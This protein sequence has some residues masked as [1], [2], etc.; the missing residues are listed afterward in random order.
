MQHFPIFLRLSGERVVVSGAGR[1]AVAKLR[2]LL[3][4]EAQLAVF[5]ADPDAEILSWQRAGRLGH[6]A[7]PVESADLEGAAL[8]YCANRDGAADD[9]AAALDR[10]HGIRV[11]IA[12]NLADSDFITPAIVDRDPVTVAIGTEGTAPVLARALKAALEAQLPTSLGPLARIAQAF[13]SRCESIAPGRARRALWSEYFFRRGPRGYAREGENGAR[14]ALRLLL[15][16]A[17]AATRPSGFV[18]FVGAG[19]GDPAL[20]TLKARDRLHDADIV[21]H[22]RLVSAQVLEL[23]RREAERVCAG[24]KGF[25]PSWSQ[26]SINALLARRAREGNHVVRLKSGDPTVFGRLD[27]EIEALDGAGI[28]WEIVPGITAAS[29]AA[30]DMGISLTRRGRN[31]ALRFL[32]GR[33]ADG[34]AEHD[35]AA[36]ARPGSVAAIYMGKRA[37]TFL[38][39]RLLMHGAAPSTPVTIVENASATDERIVATSLLRL[40]ETLEEERFDGAVVLML[41]LLPREAVRE[42]RAGREVRERAL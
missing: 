1:A 5:G 12:D 36:L 18:S 7:R 8:L 38:R 24:K 34:F 39:G 26:A 9:R 22:D 3:K 33:D 42:A 23:A 2:L 41:G 28:P 29:C 37:A 40:P 30:A 27:E 32:T 31:S 14:D 17:A 15:D 10:R 13:R 16:E 21:V 11:S 6:E 4:T 35:W 20:L 19:P 25:G